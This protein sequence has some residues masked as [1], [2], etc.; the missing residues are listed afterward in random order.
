MCSDDVFAIVVVAVCLLED[1]NANDTAHNAAVNSFQDS[2]LEYMSVETKQS[3][4]QSR[5]FT[6]KVHKKSPAN[7]GVIH[8]HRIPPA[9]GMFLLGKLEG[10]LGLFGRIC[11]E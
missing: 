7:G 9:E 5:F 3:I 10:Q 4:N 8:A 1:G 6:D 2:S 11:G